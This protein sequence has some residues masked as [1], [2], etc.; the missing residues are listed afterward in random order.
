MMKPTQFVVQYGMGIYDSDANLDVFPQKFAFTKEFFEEVVWAVQ[1]LVGVHNSTKHV[2]ETNIQ[3]NGVRIKGDS[4][5]VIYGNYNFDLASGISRSML[6][7]S[8]AAA[9]AKVKS[10]Q[11]STRV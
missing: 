7:A 2:L 11:S 1:R 6:Q 3:P 4:W 8:K 9:A 5:E 10:E